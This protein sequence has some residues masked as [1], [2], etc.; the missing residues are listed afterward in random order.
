MEYLAKLLKLEISAYFVWSHGQIRDILQVMYE[1]QITQK[2]CM[3]SW[4]QCEICRGKLSPQ[5]KFWSA[6]LLKWLDLACEKMLN[7]AKCDR[8]LTVFTVY[9]VLQTF[10]LCYVFRETFKL[11]QM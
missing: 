11:T 1:A 4:I 7:N 2:I 5:L 10:G 9:I 6:F 8:T 3:T